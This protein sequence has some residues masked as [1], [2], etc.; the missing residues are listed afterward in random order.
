MKIA[1]DASAFFSGSPGAR[2][3]FLELIPELIPLLGDGDELLV[4]YPRSSAL[5]EQLAW[6]LRGSR[7]H[8]LPVPMPSGRLDRLWRRLGFPAVERLGGQTQRPAGA[9]VCHSIAPPL[10]PTS[11]RRRV[12]TVH[13]LAVGGAR[14]PS[15]IAAGIRRAHAVVTPTTRAERAIRSLPGCA[16]ARVEVVPSGVNERF[17]KPPKVNDVEALCA[18]YPFLQEPY[19][20]ALGSATEP[21]R[22]L[23]FLL[24]SYALARGGRPDLPPL[25]FVS[26]SESAEEEIARRRLS[27]AV[28]RLEEIDRDSLPALYRGAELLL[29]PAFDN[30][31]GQSLLEAAACG[32]TAIVDPSCGALELLA[33]GVA[34]PQ[35]SSEAWAAEIVRLHEDEEL[36]REAGRRA[37]EA[38][39]RHTWAATAR[40]LWEVYSSLSPSRAR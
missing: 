6:T 38:A 8:A 23:P 26:A 14:A 27:G 16:G 11:A 24:D 10:I 5:P 17:V 29:Y 32:V 7:L 34:Q 40:R 36:R 25:V 20:L 39:R 28:L 19:F 37:Q 13:S 18:T 30:A 31:F 2:T 22:N 15:L 21:A 3:Y 1:L 35:L 4:L 9:E 33:D 12:L